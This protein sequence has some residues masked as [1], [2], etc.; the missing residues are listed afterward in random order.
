[1]P[2]GM[3]DV[4]MED[5]DKAGFR[6]LDVPIMPLQFKKIVRDLKEDPWEMV[7]MI[8]KKAPRTIKGTMLGGGLRV[9]DTGGN[10][11]EATELF[12]NMLIEMG[13]L[14][15]VQTLSVASPVG[16]IDSPGNWFTRW[17]Q[18][19][20]L[21][22]AH[23]VCY[24]MGTTRHT[25]EWYARVTKSAVDA[26]MDIIYLKDA[27]G[28][29][30]VESVRRVF[31]IIKENAPGKTLEIH[32]HCT[33]GMADVV[34]AEAMKMGCNGFHVG[35]PPMAEG[36]AQPTVFNTVE[37]AKALGF[38]P[39]IDVERLESVAKRMYRM[40]KEEGLPYDFGPTRYKVAQY[41]HR[42]PGGVISNMIHQLKELHIEH[43]VDEVV[44][45]CKRICKETGEPHMITPFSQYV[46][47]QAAI[48]VAIGER[49]KIVI[50]DFINYALGNSGPDSGYLDMDPDLKD[51]FV[52]LPRAKYLKELSNLR[53]IE[54][55]KPL[56]DLRNEYGAHLS[57]E[58]FLLRYMMKGTEEIEVMRKATTSHPFHV[59]SC[60][61]SPILD[62]ID[63]LS[64]QP[65]T[66]LVQIKL[67][68]KT[69]S[70]KRAV[71]IE[72]VN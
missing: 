66:T 21:E 23:A 20:G 11:R 35:I 27:G 61:D 45:E 71:P 1:M 34:Y 29:L 5:I 12:Y 55:D 7:K 41:D 57:D 50:D 69:L 38:E 36:T 59:Y 42:I 67:G 8:G 53:V 33:A 70:L 15:R 14:Q 16:P 30:D 48:N 32:S 54:R 64:K 28:L 72:D 47:T 18:Q 46:C 3:M 17:C 60:I 43:R 56:Q 68:D 31:Q 51:K 22:T 49:Y 26:G 39:N 40:A 44:E 37:N 10:N 2:A 19:K 6:C 13:A 9:F 65:Q 58:E 24:Y 62:L 25:D 4:V 63:G 52:N